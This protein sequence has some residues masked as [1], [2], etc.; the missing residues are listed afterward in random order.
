MPYLNPSKDNFVHVKFR[1]KPN[2]D[3]DEQFF[4]LRLK[5][6]FETCSLREINTGLQKI[7][8]TDDILLDKENEKSEIRDKGANLRNGDGSF[9]INTTVCYSRLLYVLQSEQNR[10]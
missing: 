9:D 8:G 5:L 10:R 4:G 7:L 2:S 6:L 1:C 3:L